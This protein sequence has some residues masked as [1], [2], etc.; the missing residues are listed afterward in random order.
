MKF[1]NFYYPRYWNY[2]LIIGVH[3][4]GTEVVLKPLKSNIY[5]PFPI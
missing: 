2:K 3:S 1:G 4:I 5:S